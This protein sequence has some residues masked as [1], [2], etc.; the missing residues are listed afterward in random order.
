MA[1]SEAASVIRRMEKPNNAARQINLWTLLV[2]LLLLNH[3]VGMRSDMAGAGGASGN[4]S[5]EMPPASLARLPGVAHRPLQ[6]QSTAIN[7]PD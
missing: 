4:R 7:R 3:Q 6:H 1:K 5:W 2:T